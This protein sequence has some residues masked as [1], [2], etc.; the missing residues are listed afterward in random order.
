MRYYY[1]GHGPVRFVFGTFGTEP[2]PKHN[3]RVQ[4][5]AEPNLN[6]MFR[7]GSGSNPVR[8]K[9]HVGFYYISKNVKEEEE[10]RVRLLVHAS[11]MFYIFIV[12]QKK[13]KRVETHVRL[14]V[15]TSRMNK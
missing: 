15:H 7:F 13:Q 2:E 4:P 11:P 6:I 5:K 12:Y 14:L 8:T 9:M 10:T 1:T 3:V